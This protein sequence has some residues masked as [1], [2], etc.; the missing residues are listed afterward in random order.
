MPVAGCILGCDF[1]GTIANVGSS[2]QKIWKIGDRVAGWVLG[3]NTVRKDDGAFAEYCVANGETCIKIPEGMS[4]EEAASP[5][6]GIATAGMGLFLNLGMVMPGEGEGGKRE[7][8]LV[9]GGTSATATLA[10]QF[11]NL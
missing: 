4:D 5:P 7:P 10:I 9:Y 11:G 3:N 8:V 6:A 2:V 1:S